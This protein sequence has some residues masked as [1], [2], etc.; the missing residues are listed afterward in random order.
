MFDRLSHLLGVAALAGGLAGCGVAAKP[1]APPPPV[2]QLA[3]VRGASSTAVLDATGM[4][5]RQREMAL[6]FR[7]GGV[8][9]RLSVDDG[10]VVRKG[11][12]L[13]ELDDEAVSARFRQAQAE[14]TRADAD[15]RRAAA[16]VERGAVSRQQAE[17]QEAQLAAAQAAYVAAAFDRRW[18]R[19]VAPADGVVLARV[20]QAGEVAQP[21]QIVLSIAD[22]ASPLVLRAP[23]A[24]RDAARLRMGAPAQVT[25]DALPGEVLAGRVSRIAQRAG[26][27]SGA[28]EFEVTLPERPGLRSGLIARANLAV[29]GG[30][31]GAYD[32]LPA[33]AVL[34]AD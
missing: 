15:N 25:L 27:Q 26:P 4:L 6:S 18:T 23:L 1:Q 31:T 19:L 22:A 14:L 33:E 30:P 10:D 9:T 21:G 8:I 29:A 24:D 17:A 28:I 12:V 13:A 11:Q 5:R 2:V 32:R 20:A 7:I 34:E 16:L 3:T